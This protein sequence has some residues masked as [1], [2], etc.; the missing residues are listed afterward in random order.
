MFNNLIESS[1]H[2]QEFKR[3]GSFLLFT[4]ATYLVL[5]VITGVASIY[6]YDAHLE[7]QSTELEITFMPV[8]PPEPAPPEEVR[9]AIRPASSSDRTPTQ[10]IRTQLIA[11][12]SNP[13]KVP[14]NVGTV[15]LNIP[16]ATSKSII[17]A[18][19]EEPPASP[20]NRGVPGGTGNTP[21][22]NITEPPPPPTPAPTPVVPKLVR[23]SEGVLKGNAI[24]LPK[25]IY[26]PIARQIGLQGLV[27]VQI[28]IDE[29][30]RVVSA[31]AISGHPFLIHEAQKAAMQAR[32][33]PTKLSNQPVKVSGVITY[34]FLKQ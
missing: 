22:V 6:A 31:K 10:S 3:R 8:V 28:L 4:T 15:S 16:P 20:G 5:F 24:S 19:N 11:S 2:L 14:D 26:P 1:S 34:N 27:T 21:Q 32:F 12:V 25:P 7:S 17:G 18:T 29:E 9:N 13:N 23:M 30:G 33:T